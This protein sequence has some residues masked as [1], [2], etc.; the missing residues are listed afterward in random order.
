MQRAKFIPWFK[1]ANKQYESHFAE[2][3]NQVSHYSLN[4]HTNPSF[5]YYIEAHFAE[6]KNRTLELEQLCWQNS[7]AVY[8]MDDSVLHEHER[9]MYHN[10]GVLSITSL[11]VRLDEGH[12]IDYMAYSNPLLIEYI[13]KLLHSANINDRC[14]SVNISANKAA[15][16]LLE[17]DYCTLASWDGLCCNEEAV[18]IILAMA[19]HNNLD[20]ITHNKNLK[21]LMTNEKIKQHTKIFGN[22]FIFYNGQYEHLIRILEKTEWPTFMSYPLE[23]NSLPG[24]SR[25]YSRSIHLKHPSY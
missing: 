25:W 20:K 21:A 9:G 1:K 6:L 13:K 7:A 3:E 22:G 5:V 23:C 18:S 10:L 8:L 16:S 19:K 11:R 12:K 24:K 4:Q 14:I 17:G 15:V 2:A